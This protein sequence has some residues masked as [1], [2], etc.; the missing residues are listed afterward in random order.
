MVEM[1]YL[2]LSAV[3][4]TPSLFTDDLFGGGLDDNAST[5]QQGLAE[6]KGHTH[7]LGC[8]SKRGVLHVFI[9][10]GHSVWSHSH[11]GS[12]V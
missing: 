10:H 9:I 1:D 2:L 7:N 4:I 5:G 11:C 8:P 3:V 12:E 6:G